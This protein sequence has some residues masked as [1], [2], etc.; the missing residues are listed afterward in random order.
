MDLSRDLEL[1]FETFLGRG[2]L[3]Q[4]ADVGLEGI[5]HVAEGPRQGPDLI[6][7]LRSRQLEIQV[8]G[9]DPSSAAGERLDRFRHSSGKPDHDRDE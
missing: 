6:L 5:T 9:R 1:V 3:S 7:R 8:A 4:I 2:R